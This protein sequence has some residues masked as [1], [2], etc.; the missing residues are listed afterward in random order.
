MTSYPLL[1]HCDPVVLS[2]SRFFLFS[3]PVTHLLNTMSMTAFFRTSLGIRTG[4]PKLLAAM[5]AYSLVIRVTFFSRRILTI[6]AHKKAI[7]SAFLR[8]IHLIRLLRIKHLAAILTRNCIVHMA[9]MFCK[10]HFSKF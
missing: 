8:A 10:D 3:S 2:I 5:N 4:R 9:S 1:L 7:R 6:A